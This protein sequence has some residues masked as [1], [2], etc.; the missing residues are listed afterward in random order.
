M[1]GF[2]VDDDAADDEEVPVPARRRGAYALEAL[3]QTQKVCWMKPLTHAAAA[4]A[5]AKARRRK[6]E[7][8]EADPHGPKI[9]EGEEEFDPESLVVSKVRPALLRHTSHGE[10]FAL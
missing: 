2:I 7:P 1:G 3:V 6:R 5:A 8:L 10:A 9:N 4:A